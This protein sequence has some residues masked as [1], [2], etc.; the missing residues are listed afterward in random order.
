M[1]WERN[2]MSDLPE[3][4]RLPDEKLLLAL[5]VREENLQD[6]KTWCEERRQWYLASTKP[7]LSVADVE[8]LQEWSG[9][10]WTEAAGG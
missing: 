1:Q 2:D 5:C 9:R 10:L 8:R 6:P 4:L 3:F 7:D